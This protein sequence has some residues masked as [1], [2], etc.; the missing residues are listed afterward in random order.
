MV[1]HCICHDISFGEL[2]ALAQRVGPDLPTLSRL[3]GCGTN[4]GR[5]LPYIRL[6]L[7]TGRTRF[8]VMNPASL[9]PPTRTSPQTPPPQT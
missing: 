9:E 6:M 3:T 4:C 2:H 1:T 8:P 7:E 5:C